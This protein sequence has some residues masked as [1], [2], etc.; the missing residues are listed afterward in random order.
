MTTVLNKAQYRLCYQCQQRHAN[1]SGKCSQC[2][3]RARDSDV[4]R[5]MARKLADWLRRHGYQKPFPGT[6][7][8]RT[9]IKQCDGQSSLSG[10]TDLNKLSVILVDP[11]DAWVPENALLVTIDESYALTRCATMRRLV[12]KLNQQQP[13]AIP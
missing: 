2:A 4:A 12:L 3:N 9:V 10:V 11:D 1:K 8:I 13:L 6:Q 5:Y 7:F